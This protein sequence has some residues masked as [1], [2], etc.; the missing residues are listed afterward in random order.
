MAGGPVVSR[1]DISGVYMI[2]GDPR[3]DRFMTNVSSDSDYAP[4]VFNVTL[5]PPSSHCQYPRT[6]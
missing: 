1:I 2:V 6:R 4:V 5:R 3:Y